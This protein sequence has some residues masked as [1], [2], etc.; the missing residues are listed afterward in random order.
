MRTDPSVIQNLQHDLPL[1]GSYLNGKAFSDGVYRVVPAPFQRGLEWDEDTFRSLLATLVPWEDNDLA[2]LQWLEA[3]RK[4]LAG[5]DPNTIIPDICYL[6]EISIQPRHH[7]ENPKIIELIDGQQRTFCTRSMVLS[8]AVAYCEA[9]SDYD[10]HMELLPCLFTQGFGR[11][12]QPQHTMVFENEDHAFNNLC[13]PFR[14]SGPDQQ[15]LE[16]RKKALEDYRQLVADN[17]S[18]RKVKSPQMDLYLEIDSQLNDLINELVG[19]E[20]NNRLAWIEAITLRL[21]YGTQVTLTALHKDYDAATH[22]LHKNNTGKDLSEYAQ[23][24][25]VLMATEKNEDT[26]EAIRTNLNKIESEIHLYTKRSDMQLT[27]N[28]GASLIGLALNIEHH[29][30]AFQTASGKTIAR[31]ERMR[32]EAI[33]GKASFDPLHITK[34]A[35]KLLPVYLS[36]HIKEAAK[37]WPKELSRELYVAIDEFRMIGQRAM[38]HSILYALRYHE[39]DALRLTRALTA[40][41]LQ[42]RVW[43]TYNKQIN[44]VVGRRAASLHH[45]I[46]ATFDQLQ[47]APDKLKFPFVDVLLAQCKKCDYYSN[48]LNTNFIVGASSLTMASTS[49]ELQ[50][51]HRLIIRHETSLFAESPKILNMEHILPQTPDAYVHKEAKTPRSQI[52]NKSYWTSICNRLGNYIPL[53]RKANSSVGNRPFSQKKLEYAKHGHFPSVKALA[54]RS[55]FTVYDVETR[56]LEQAKLLHEI[57]GDMLPDWQKLT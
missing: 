51:M 2:K 15:V 20:H 46:K 7:S 24:R 39:K 57:I 11:R 5:A 18:S 56:S 8:L 9:S 35:L 1:L 49:K 50:L 25:A 17:Q 4:A 41:C 3:G 23:I 33:Q 31:L 19:S 53:N 13:E 52:S 40:M 29:G 21:L 30:E 37:L 27:L 32:L 34:L 42:L 55:E 10:F 47:K 12:T 45:A 36:T 44:V 43:E 22:F 54:A 26:K 6:Q 48:D 16:N 14:L 38:Y 28:H